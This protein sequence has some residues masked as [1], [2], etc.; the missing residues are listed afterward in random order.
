MAIGSWWLVKGKG[1]CNW[2]F[3]LFGRHRGIHQGDSTCY[4]NLGFLIQIFWAP[5]FVEVSCD[6]L[7]EFNFWH[8]EFGHFIVS[9]CQW[10]HLIF[11]IFPFSP[12]VNHSQNFITWLSPNSLKLIHCTGIR[13]STPQAE[14]LGHVG[15]KKQTYRCWPRWTCSA[16]NKFLESK[17]ISESVSL[18]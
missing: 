15:A 11:H 3:K 9:M 10:R 1:P 7:S 12:W 16:T 17:G 13:L 14:E 4:M 8:L 6:L 2:P 18:E 5:S